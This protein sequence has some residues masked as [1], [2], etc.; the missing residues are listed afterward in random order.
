MT[1]LRT[2]N[3][4]F[5]HL[6]ATLAVIVLHVFYRIDTQ[7]V[8]CGAA[9]Y[10]VANPITIGDIEKEFQGITGRMQPVGG[11]NTRNFIGGWRWTT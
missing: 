4:W 10:N 9:F 1:I 2:R 7:T 8:N 6:T 3:S 5:R 11:V